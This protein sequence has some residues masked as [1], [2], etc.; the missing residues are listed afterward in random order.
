[1]GEIARRL[2]E[3]SGPQA[4]HGIIPHALVKVEEGYKNG[5]GNGNDKTDGGGDTAAG[6]GK[7]A[8]RVTSTGEQT[9][10]EEYGV[11]TLVPDM[12]TRKR[13]MAKEVINGGPGS[14][15]VVL[16]GGFGTLE[17]AMEMTTWN[18]LGI[19]HRGIVLLNIEGYYDGVLQ[20]LQ[21][22]VEQ[23]FVSAANQSILGECK[24]P[25]EALKILDKYR[26]SEGRYKLDWGVQQG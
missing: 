10:N 22:S 11:T 15:F 8:E 18:Q 6:P 17:E 20:W 5:N 19:H 23:E 3:L 25:E 9:V 16:P 4:V 7:S 24:E 13:L 2:V 1:M 26:V 12:H 21:R 14:G